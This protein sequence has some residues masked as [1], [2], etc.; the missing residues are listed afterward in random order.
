MSQSLSKT[1]VHLV[2]STKNRKPSIPENVRNRL[3]AYIIGA[4][5]GL[6][7]PAIRVGGPNDHVHALFV[8]SKNRALSEIVREVK[9]SSSKW[10][11]AHTSDFYWQ[12]GYGAFSIGESAVAP[13][14]EYIDRQVEH[15]HKTTFEEEFRKLC[16]QYN[17]ELKEEYAWD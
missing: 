11:K 10:M 17:V 1:L 16:A 4:F 13:L 15:H 3:H 8:L 9:Q 6:D 7:S 12:T 2:F 14:C 5:S